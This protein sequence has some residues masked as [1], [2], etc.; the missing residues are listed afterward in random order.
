M[1][2]DWLSPALKVIG[3]VK[4]ADVLREKV[5]LLT[6]QREDALRKLA[7]AE[8]KSKALEVEVA[9]LKQEVRDLRSSV[10][11]QTNSGPDV[12]HEEIE[13]LRLL[14]DAPYGLQFHDLAEALKIKR[15]KLDYHM[16]RLGNLNLA[17]VSDHMPGIE[18][19]SIRA[20][21]RRLLVQKGLL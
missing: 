4:V 20:E 6:I 16:D 9:K 19:A 21:G 18:S 12:A 11:R 17:D 8:A 3:D 1:I 14:A 13:I 7:E 10:A 15:A 2:P 5:G